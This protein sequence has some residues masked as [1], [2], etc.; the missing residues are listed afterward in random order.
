MTELTRRTSGASEIPSSA[1]RSSAS[2]SSSSTKPSLRRRRGHRTPRRRAPGGGSRRGCR[3]ATRRRARAGGASRAGARRSRGCCR[4]RRRRRGACRPR[5]RTGSRRRA[6]GRGA[7]SA[8]PPPRPPSS[9]AGRRAASGSG[10]RACGRFLRAEATPSS[11]IACASEPWAARPRTSASLSGG[12]RPVAASRSAT[13]SAS[14]LIWNGGAPGGCESAPAPRSSLPT[15]RRLGGGSK[16][17]ISL[18]RVIGKC[19][20]LLDRGCGAGRGDSPPTPPH[21]QR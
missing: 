3:R 19:G 18:V 14:G 5:A 21:L 15:V 9:R 7:G 6:R 13:S 8:S 16:S 2:S 10:P 4:G 11:M 20:A 12:I 1:S 17:V